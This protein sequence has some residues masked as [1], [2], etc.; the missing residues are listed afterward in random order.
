MPKDQLAYSE[1]LSA[2]KDL[3]IDPTEEIG[4]LYYNVL[5]DQL[6]DAD[7]LNPSFKKKIIYTVM[8]RHYQWQGIYSYLHTYFCNSRP[9]LLFQAMHGV[10]A[11]YIER[12]FKMAQFQNPV[13]RLR[14]DEQIR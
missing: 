6:Y 9:N 7:K 8:T 12:A 3:I 2:F 14:T 5:R 11:N 4:D 13:S 1:D 10:G